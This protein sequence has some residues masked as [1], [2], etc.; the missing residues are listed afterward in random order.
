MKELNSFT[1]EQLN[2]FIKSDHAQCGDVAALAR[3]ALAA[4]RA[5]PVGYLEQNHL[6][7]LRS[8]SDADIWPE[9][10]AGD[11]PIYLTP[12][13][14]SPEIPDGWI[15]C[16]DRMPEDDQVVVIIN[17]GH[18]FLYEAA[19]VTR[20]GPHFDLMDGLEASNYDGGEVVR[21]DMEATH[22]MPLPAAPEKEN[23]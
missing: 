17:S 11:I 9:G 3:I 6:D 14:N 23:G 8:G 16:S 5:E 7:Y 20:R 13:P 10:G 2:D 22:W 21:L 1:V 12:Q 18:G 15:K 4:K 19:V